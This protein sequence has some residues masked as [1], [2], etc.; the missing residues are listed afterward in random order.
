[1]SDIPRV[2]LSYANNGNQAA[3]EWPKIS[4]A[5]DSIAENFQKTFEPR[6][7]VQLEAISAAFQSFSKPLSFQL[8]DA[9]CAL[10][11]IDST[12]VAPFCYQ[13]E[14]ENEFACQLLYSRTTSLHHPL[15][16]NFL[17]IV[18]R[19]LQSL[20]H[21]PELRQQLGEFL[22]GRN[23]NTSRRAFISRVL[24]KIPEFRAL[25]AFGESEISE[26][27]RQLSAIINKTTS[28]L[29]SRFLRL[30]RNDRPRFVFRFSFRPTETF[31]EQLWPLLMAF[32]NN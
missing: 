4:I 12:I 10:K 23:R 9:E 13:Q 7:T 11:I 18:Q 32:K 8:D 14:S 6:L 27:W 31:R 29:C 2:F 30:L 19:L 5:L 25:L 22:A 15:K 21:H 24:M 1:M 17:Y 16:D 28:W 20:G 26:L 3:V